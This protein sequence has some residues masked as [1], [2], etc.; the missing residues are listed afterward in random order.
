MEKRSESVGCS[1]SG[2]PLD[3][4]KQLVAMLERNAEAKKAQREEEGC[5][6]S[7]AP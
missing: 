4:L 5:R 2:K 7:S 3:A 6:L 1:G